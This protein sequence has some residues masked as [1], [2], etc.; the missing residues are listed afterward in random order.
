MCSSG[1]VAGWLGGAV[2]G[3]ADGISSGAVGGSP[4]LS[5]PSWGG[6]G[7]LSV[8]SPNS[9]FIQITLRLIKILCVLRL[10]MR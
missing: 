8:S 10:S 9:L 5:L 1:G 3:V 4:R 7:G 6:I 2:V